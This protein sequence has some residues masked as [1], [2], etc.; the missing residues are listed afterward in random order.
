MYFLEGPQRPS[1]QIIVIEQLD[2]YLLFQTAFTSQA[3]R[4]G[5]AIR[6]KQPVW[7]LEEPSIIENIYIK[8]V[9]IW[10]PLGQ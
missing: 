6:T 4:G 7:H 2:P 8:N 10:D 5:H 1:S 9:R 3:A